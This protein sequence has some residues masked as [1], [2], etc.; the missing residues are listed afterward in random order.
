MDVTQHLPW[1]TSQWQMIASFIE[2][3]RFPQA[4]LLTGAEGLGK[5]YFATQLAQILLCSSFSLKPC[6]Q[7]QACQWQEQ[8]PDLRRI[9]AEEETIKVDQIRELQEFVHI[10][11]YGNRQVVIIQ[12][13]ERMTLAAANSVLK[14]LEEPPAKNH[15][16]LTTANPKLLLPTIRSRCCQIRFMPNQEEA[17][18]AWL[19]NQGVAAEQAQEALELS[20]GRP[21]HA[22]SMA[23][24]QLNLINELQQEVMELWQ[25]QGQAYFV[26]CTRWAEHDLPLLLNT[27]FLV[28]NRYIQVKMG[29]G[30]AFK[31]LSAEGSV[32]IASISLAKLLDFN[33][34][35]IRYRQK[36][37]QGYNF[38]KPLF[39]DELLINLMQMVK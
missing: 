26:Y 21:F 23:A 37:V 22:L 28:I 15:F 13:A 35:L 2:M 16:I 30:T 8:H 6:G 14:I 7:C 1:H 38:S 11:S 18:L 20:E 5:H 4:L 17:S 25:K 33:Q 3:Q 29:L 12:A 27:L 39:L 36:L 10:T 24:K 9:E 32:K 31:G 34:L 19:Q